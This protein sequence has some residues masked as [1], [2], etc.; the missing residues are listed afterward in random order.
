VGEGGAIKPVPRWR[1]SSG[2]GHSCSRKDSLGVTELCKLIEG[3]RLEKCKASKSQNP[4]NSNPWNTRQFKRIQSKKLELEREIMSAVCRE[5]KEV[6]VGKGQRLKGGS[7][8]DSPDGR[9]RSVQRVKDS[10]GGCEEFGVRPAVL[11]MHRSGALQANRLLDG[12]WLIPNSCRVSCAEGKC[13]VT[14][15][16]FRSHDWSTGQ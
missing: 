2:D 14:G 9:R 1:L 13:G 8:T 12:N 11:Y 5:Y 3:A 10:K 16:N 4:W 15:Q 6:G 7:P